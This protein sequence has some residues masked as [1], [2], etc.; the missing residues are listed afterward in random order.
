MESNTGE[1]ANSATSSLKPENATLADYIEATIRSVLATASTSPPRISEA[2]KSEVECEPAKVE[3]S[4]SMPEPASTKEDSI[5]PEPIQKYEVDLPIPAEEDAQEDAPKSISI[6]A[7]DSENS[8]S[9]PTVG[10]ETSKSASTYLVFSLP[11]NSLVEVNSAPDNVPKRKLPKTRSSQ[12]PDSPWFC[13]SCKRG[14]RSKSGLSQH[15]NSYHSGPKPFICLTC[16]KRF[17]IAIMLE[18]HMQRHRAEDK[19]YKCT[20]CD[21]QYFN[22]I[23][24]R[25]HVDLRH[26]TAEFHCRHCNHP[27]SRYDHL[28]NHERT[29]TASRLKPTAEKPRLTAQKP[30]EVSSNIPESNLV[31]ISSDSSNPAPSP[32][33]VVQTPPSKGIEESI[34]ISSD[35][36]CFDVDELAISNHPTVKNMLLKALPGSSIIITT[37]AELAKNPILVE[38][39]K[40]IGSTT[41]QPADVVSSP[42]KPTTSETGNGSG[43]LGW[44]CT[45]CHR[46]F[47]SKRG[48]TQHEATMHIWSKVFQCYMCGKRHKDEEG[49]K[50]HQ[51]QYHANDESRDC[52]QCGE[53]FPTNEALKQHASIQHNA[54]TLEEEIA[55]PLSPVVTRSQ[56]ASDSTE[57][58]QTREIVSADDSES[59][60]TAPSSGQDQDYAPSSSDST[61]SSNRSSNRPPRFGFSSNSHCSLCN[62]WFRS[63]GGLTQHIST[64]HSGPKPFACPKCNKKYISEA[65]LDK[66]KLSHETG[67]RQYKC[68][69]CDKEFN[70]PQDLKRHIVAHHGEIPHKCRCCGGT[71]QRLDHLLNHEMKHSHRCCGVRVAMRLGKDLP[72]CYMEK[73]VLPDNM[74]PKRHLKGL[75]HMVSDS[76]DTAANAESPS[77]NEPLG[78][79]IASVIGQAHIQSDSSESK[80]PEDEPH[81]AAID[82]LSGNDIDSIDNTETSHRDDIESI[83]EEKIPVIS[84]WYCTLCKRS[85][86]S[87]HGLCQHNK[88]C[89]SSQRLHVCGVCGKRFP[90]PERLSLHRERHIVKNKSRQC[91]QCKKCFFHQS[92]LNRHVRTSHGNARF[93]CKYCGKGFGRDDHKVAHERFHE[94]RKR[95]SG[96]ARRL[97]SQALLGQDSTSLDADVQSDRVSSPMSTINNDSQEEDDECSMDDVASSNDGVTEQ[98]TQQQQEN[99]RKC[100]TVKPQR[101]KF[102]L[103]IRM[104]QPTGLKGR[105]GIHS[106]LA[107]RRL[108]VECNRIFR[109]S[110]GLELHRQEHH[111]GVKNGENLLPTKY[112]DATTNHNALQEKAHIQE[113]IPKNEQ[114]ASLTSATPTE[115]VKETKSTKEPVVIVVNTSDSE[116]GLPSPTANNEPGSSTKVD[117][118]PPKLYQYSCNA[119]ALRFESKDELHV[120]HKQH[121]L[122]CNKCSL[123][124][125]NMQDV[126]RHISQFHGVPQMAARKS[127]PK[128]TNTSPSPSQSK[129]VS[130]PSPKRA[131]A[132]SL[133]SQSKASPQA[134][135]VK[136]TITISEI[137]SATSRQSNGDAGKYRVSL[138]NTL[139]CA[140]AACRTFFKT[141]DEYME[142][143]DTV[144]KG[145]EDLCCSFCNKQFDTRRAVSNHERTHKKNITLD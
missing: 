117:H 97:K 102:S 145:Y 131:N 125:N 71:F 66:H 57:K 35:S 107:K 38:A 122:Q 68:K 39:N 138:P 5:L 129:A 76:S 104:K 139:Y 29:H 119:C 100:V 18:R 67:G 85:F 142:H 113:T 6:P 86:R 61:A 62:R 56:R 93:I 25:R 23:D 27:F 137:I 58:A 30:A 72:I 87:K 99:D 60:D 143:M 118:T 123:P 127:S 94:R 140:A 108:C 77:I 80:E 26:G 28:V 10:G 84:G 88:I 126:M 54:A 75:Y 20:F 120:H 116:Q 133:P 40:T 46:S 59:N 79:K 31:E 13:K 136:P 42:K 83:A 128:R 73:E 135:K 9:V 4:P 90:T 64:H 69:D 70:Y 19:P 44:P 11:S 134:A 130:K 81:A 47:D 21:K 43:A 48:L 74:I 89:H 98:L 34:E 41:Q 103:K 111:S 1:P 12:L 105:L 51:R 95:K 110:I 82:L 92:D 17:E 101:K 37:S 65:L 2:I 124:F 33:P 22:N 115:A 55:P 132:S 141:S 112:P 14:F 91:H 3:D 52:S 7:T 78:I 8:S 16:N 32:E 63:R 53:S 96:T 36:S 49:M 15:N 144:H 50:A 114:N 106:K 121:R 109:S 24:L 45:Q